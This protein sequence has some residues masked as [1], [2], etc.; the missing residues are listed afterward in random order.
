MDC[1]SASLVAGDL[2]LISD[3][4]NSEPAVDVQEALLFSQLYADY[5]CVGSNKFESPN[6]WRKYY[7]DALL[8][9]QWT[10]I[11]DQD[12]KTQP[13]DNAAISLEAMIEAYVLKPLNRVEADAIRQLFKRMAG[14]AETDPVALQLY[15][16]GVKK[17]DEE[18][19][20][21]TFSVQF[22][23]FEAP[24]HMVSLFVTFTTT[25]TVGPDPL[26]QA[27]TGRH[28][29]GDVEAFFSRRTWNA[30]NYDAIRKSIR[31]F[32]NGR[33]QT[34]ILPIPCEVPDDIDQA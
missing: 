18:G 16:Y 24:T 28:L 19:G 34:L 32:L 33:Q 9:A 10:I 22:S 5:K 12:Y 14:L 17:A 27:F 29:V 20:R 30:G 11:D 26:R 3:V 13:Q 25:E 2:L 21:S 7:E 15:Q 6:A 23:V 4:S 31:D 8:H 1:A